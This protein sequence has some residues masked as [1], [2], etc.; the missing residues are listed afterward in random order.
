MR[1][2]SEETSKRNQEELSRH[3]DISHWYGTR[4]VQCCGVFPKSMES[5]GME[6]L[7]Y[8][9]CE[10]CGKRTGLYEMP[11]QAR[12]AWNNGITY[13]ESNQLVLFGE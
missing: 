11:W 5:G 10:V 1:Y 12:D 4:C 13:F 3:F 6:N 9:Q 7:S 8:Y 2:I